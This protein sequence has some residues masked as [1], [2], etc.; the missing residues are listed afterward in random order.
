MVSPESAV[1]TIVVDAA[2]VF[3]GH[4]Q[5]EEGARRSLDVVDVE[6]DV[7]QSEIEDLV[8]EGISVA[9]RDS[10]RWCVIR[11]GMP[12]YK[13]VK[14][15]Q[16]VRVRLLNGVVVEGRVKQTSED[17]AVFSRSAEVFVYHPASVDPARPVALVH[18]HQEHG[19][20]KETG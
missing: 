1:D 18:A 5:R 2:P 16:S 20:W 12:S 19:L 10:R 13:E 17:G 8:N 6:R 4:W 14:P 3:V 9:V 15:G 7:K 11:E